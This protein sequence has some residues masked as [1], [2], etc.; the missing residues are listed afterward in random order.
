MLSI[1]WYAIGRRPRIWYKRPSLK[2][3]PH[4]K[5]LTK[6]MPFRHGSTKSQSIT[7]SITSVKNG[8]APSPS[9]SRSN[10]KTESF[11]GNSPISLQAPNENCSPRKRALLSKTPSPLYQ[12]STVSPLSFDTARI[13]HTRKSARFWISPSVP[14]KPESSALE[15]CSKRN[16]DH[17]LSHDSINGAE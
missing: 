6:N 15:K 8:S 7:A 11:S 2:H 13:S 3:S 9:T 5:P 14:S 16:S 1:A 12:R 17:I 4:W 10:Q